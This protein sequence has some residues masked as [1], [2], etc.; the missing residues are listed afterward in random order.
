MKKLGYGLFIIWV[1]GM[2]WCEYNRFTEGIWYDAML[3]S[4][5]KFRP[6]LNH[7]KELLFAKQWEKA[8]ACSEAAIQI[9]PAHAGAYINSAQAAIELAYDRAKKA[10]ELHR[11]IRWARWLMGLCYTTG[12]NQEFLEINEQLKDL[13][14][15]KRIQ[16]ASQC[17]E[18]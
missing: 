3:R 2:T 16:K 4:P 7:S 18:S 14:T 15:V 6:L 10:F 17:E 1:L 5:G 11:D 8:L 9:D 13:K 12:R